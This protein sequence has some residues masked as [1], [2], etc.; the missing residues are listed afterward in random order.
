MRT[1]PRIF[2]LR[3]SESLGGACGVAPQTVE[4]PLLGAFRPLHTGQ[5]MPGA[6]LKPLF[7][8]SQKKPSINHQRALERLFRGT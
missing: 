3:L 6:L 1:L 4:K 2:L 5:F 8:Q 7:G